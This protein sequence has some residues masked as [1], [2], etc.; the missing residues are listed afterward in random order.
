M[1]NFTFSTVT[2]EAFR[3][4]EKGSDKAFAAGADIKE[5][6]DRGFAEM[7]ATDWFADWQGLAEIRTPTIAAVSGS[8]WPVICQMP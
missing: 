1:A 4:A 6:A 2:I 3:T 7:F 5:M 8:P